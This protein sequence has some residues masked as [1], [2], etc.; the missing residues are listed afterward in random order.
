MSPGL[1]TPNSTT[2]RST[3]GPPAS[4]RHTARPKPRATSRGR[5]ESSSTF[6]TASGRPTSVLYERGLVCTR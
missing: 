6:S 1:R 4:A 3:E 2:R 5:S